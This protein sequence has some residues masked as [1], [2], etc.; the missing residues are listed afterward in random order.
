M[1]NI[2]KEELLKKFISNKDVILNLL[3][4][5][6]KVFDYTTKNNKTWK[7]RIELMNSLISDFIKETFYFDETIK[8]N[9]ELLELVKNYNLFEFI[10]WEIDIYDEDLGNSYVFFQEYTDKIEWDNDINTTLKEAQFNWYSKLYEEVKT[11][12]I[13]SLEWLN[14]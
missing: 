1:K 5:N 12:F 11:E 7:T 2:N 4:E 6:R 14:K 8:T 13:K 3:I 10:D 9:N